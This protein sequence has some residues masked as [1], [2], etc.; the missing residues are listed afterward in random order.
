MSA[1]TCCSQ[2]GTAFAMTESKQS[3][4][5]FQDCGAREIGGR[6]GGGRIRSDGGAVLLRQTDQRLDLLPRLAQ[7]FLDGRAQERVQHS[8]QEM[9][10][11]RVYG[12][13][14]GNE[15]INNH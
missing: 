1:T 15:D 3:S 9:I 8:V 13:A 14:L 11:Q 5:G 7:C 4:F 12:L 6:F 2:G 10:S